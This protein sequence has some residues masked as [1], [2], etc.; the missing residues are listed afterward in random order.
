M[1]RT[2]RNGTTLI[3]RVLKVQYTFH[4]DDGSGVDVVTVGEGMDSGDKAANKAMS[5]AQKYAFLQTFCIPTEEQ[6]DSEVDHY[7][8]APK[9]APP[10]KRPP[11]P[12]DAAELKRGAMEAAAAAGLAEAKK[13][14][15]PEMIYDNDNPDRRKRLLNILRNM[16]PR[17]PEDFFDAIAKKLHGR[18]TIELK[19]VINEV[20]A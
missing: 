1:E 13:I 11:P 9:N 18:P 17:V 5:A 3:Y 2:Y 7:E 8:V 4:A 16:Q 12:K 20:I 6:K 15:N 19:S 10:A 14:Q